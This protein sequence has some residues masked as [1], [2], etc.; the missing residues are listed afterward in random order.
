MGRRGKEELEEADD[1]ETDFVTESDCQALIF[2][3]DKFFQ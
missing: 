1:T 3:E 2:T